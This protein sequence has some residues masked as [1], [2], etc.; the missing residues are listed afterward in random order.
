MARTLK[1]QIISQIYIYIH[2]LIFFFFNS[3]QPVH[4]ELN[5][6]LVLSEYGI[7][8]RKNIEEVLIKSYVVWNV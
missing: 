2:K 3:P 7:Q 5:A 4:M 6:C 8:I 1:M